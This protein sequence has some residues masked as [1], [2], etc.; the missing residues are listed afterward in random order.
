MPVANHYL[1]SGQY[2]PHKT[3]RGD[4]RW[5]CV[6]GLSVQPQLVSDRRGCAPVTYPPFMRLPL[7]QCGHAAI[8]HGLCHRA[9]RQS[10][11]KLRRTMALSRTA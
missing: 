7:G 4:W 9:Q 5:D 1:R 8:S 3:G 6:A 10:F 11:A 2:R